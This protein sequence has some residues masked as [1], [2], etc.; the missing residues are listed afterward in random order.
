MSAYHISSLILKFQLNDTNVIAEL[1]FFCING[2]YNDTSTN[3]LQPS[4]YFYQKYNF[5][6]HVTPR[7]TC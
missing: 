2:H 4:L 3:V 1:C 7:G 6:S 5:S